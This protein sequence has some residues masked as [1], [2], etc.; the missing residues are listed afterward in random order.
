MTQAVCIKAQRRTSR[1][2]ALDSYKKGNVVAEGKTVE[3]VLE[4]ARK[5]GKHFSMMYIPSRDKKYI[6]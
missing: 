5:S 3:D 4:R 2:V 6:F 1:F